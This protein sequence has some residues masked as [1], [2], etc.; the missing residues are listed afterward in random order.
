M[1]CRLGNGWFCERVKSDRAGLRGC[2]G[3]CEFRG[4]RGR[5]GE[6]V[7]LS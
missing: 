6:G 3:E 1:V 5:G 7:Y 4:L 2:G